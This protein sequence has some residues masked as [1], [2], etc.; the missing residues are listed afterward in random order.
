MS[1]RKK[2]PRS[3]TRAFDEAVGAR[4][5]ALRNQLGLSQLKFAV[6]LDISA[7][8]LQKYETGANKLSFGRAIE[9]TELFGISLRELAG[10]DDV[11]A[12]PPGKPASAS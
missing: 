5:R 12:K 3:R 1:L 9:I 8:Q 10:L 11:P 6:K 7:Q 4:L 2:H